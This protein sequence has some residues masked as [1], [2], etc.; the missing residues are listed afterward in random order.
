MEWTWGGSSSGIFSVKDAYLVISGG[1]VGPPHQV[2]SCS[3]FSLL[4]KSFAPLKAQITAWRLLRDCLPTRDNLNKRFSL[5]PGEL[6]CCCCNQQPE[7][8][9]HFFLH[10]NEVSR[11][12]GRV[13]NWIG[14]SWTS[15][16]SIFTHFSQFV[17]LIGGSKFRKRHLV[18]EL[19]Q[20]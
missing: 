9:S 17:G 14:V 11:L 18:L 20:D 13:S 7:T 1:T 6:L 19:H 5:A 15:A 8:A 2:P 3:V 16:S 4:W 12:W 10:C